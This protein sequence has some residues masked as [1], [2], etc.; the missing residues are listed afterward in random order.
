MTASI[1]EKLLEQY[2]RGS[3]DL[4]L[5]RAFVDRLLA[6]DNVAKLKEAKRIGIHPDSIIALC[7]LFAN[8]TWSVHKALSPIEAKEAVS[9]L[10]KMG[11]DLRRLLRLSE[12]PMSD[13]P[14]RGEPSSPL[15][16]LHSTAPQFEVLG[17]FWLFDPTSMRTLWDVAGRDKE[18]GLLGGLADAIEAAIPALNKI[19]PAHRPAHLGQREFTLRWDHLAR[20]KA[21][22]RCDE[23]GAWFFAVTFGSK[24]GK[25]YDAVAFAKLRTRASFPK[26]S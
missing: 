4:E 2:Q 17:K 26:K 23:L 13:V 10:R 15:P 20:P 8:K 11:Q 25:A 9:E 5:D 1:I 6:R 18:E 14:T 24:D 7:C 21:K 19:T 3:S 12:L 16:L 22:G